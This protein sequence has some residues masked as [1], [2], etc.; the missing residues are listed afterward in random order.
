MWLAQGNMTSG[1]ARSDCSAQSPSLAQ[2]NWDGGSL[3]GRVKH[4]SGRGQS[5]GPEQNTD[6][7]TDL[8]YGLGKVLPSLSLGLAAVNGALGSDL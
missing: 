7:T 8:L 1:K 2:C 4:P 5:P 3:G 6:S